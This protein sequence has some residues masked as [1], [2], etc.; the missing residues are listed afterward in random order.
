MIVRKSTTWY[1]YY[2]IWKKFD[3]YLSCFWI[4]KYSKIIFEKSQWCFKQK[5]KM[6]MVKLNFEKRIKENLF[7]FLMD[8]IYVPLTARFCFLRFSFIN[9][10]GCSASTKIELLS[11]KRKCNWWKWKLNVFWTL[12]IYF[13]HSK[14][15]LI[16]VCCGWI[17]FLIILRT[18][19]FILW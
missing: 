13:L 19:N 3:T 7:C 18:A 14:E 17:L 12:K 6:L 9:I 8:N 5:K 10:M 2:C 15:M 16:E 4:M 1:L 11:S